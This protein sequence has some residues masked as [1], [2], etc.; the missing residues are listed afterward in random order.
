MTVNDV[1]NEVKLAYSDFGLS[2]DV[3]RGLVYKVIWQLEKEQPLQETLTGL[4]VQ[5][6]YDTELQCRIAD[7]TDFVLIV[8]VPDYCMVYELPDASQVRL[9]SI[10]GHDELQVVKLLPYN[11]TLPVKG[12][13]N[14]QSYLSTSSP[15]QSCLTDARFTTDRPSFSPIVDLLYL[16]LSGCGEAQTELNQFLADEVLVIGHRRT[17]GQTSP[18]LEHYGQVI[19][20]RSIQ[21]AGLVVKDTRGGV[22]E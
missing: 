9:A 20:E 22:R 7:T 10:E 13:Q 11:S 17:L 5:T 4:R 8:D 2:D 1:V 3:V 19:L 18:T 15:V 12:V 21:L 6:Y 14:L 16:K